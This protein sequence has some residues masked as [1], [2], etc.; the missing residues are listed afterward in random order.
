[1]TGTFLGALP[2]AGTWVPMDVPVQKFLD[3]GLRPSLSVDVETN[4]PGDMFNQMR[5]VLAL[6]RAIATAQGVRAADGSWVSSTRRSRKLAPPRSRLVIGAI[7]AFM[8]RPV[9]RAS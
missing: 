1:M 9:P 3:R 8:R 6:Q 4:V 5:S 2:P 7:R